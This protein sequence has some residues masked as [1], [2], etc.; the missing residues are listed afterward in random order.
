[1]KRWAFWLTV[2]CLVAAPL[3]AFA[4][5][6]P[7]IAHLT[8]DGVA[9]TGDGYLNSMVIITDGTNQCTVALYDN[10]AA[11]GTLVFGTVWTAAA[12]ATNGDGFTGGRWPFALGLYADMTTGGDCYVTLG[13]SRSPAP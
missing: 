9:V 3:W 1:M 7:Q 4:R 10:T 13:W 2:S 8:A 5:G 11:S 12:T 6:G